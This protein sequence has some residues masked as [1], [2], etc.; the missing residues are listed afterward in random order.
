LEVTLNKERSTEEYKQVIQSVHEDVQ[1]MQQLTKSLLE[2]AKTGTQGSI[3]LSEVRIDEVLLKV[4]ADVQKNSSAYKVILQFG[5]FPDDDRA[6]LV[7]GNIDLLYSS[8]RNIADNGCKF[9]FDH[10][11]MI[12]LLFEN[13]NVIVQFTN[14]GD[15]I[16]EEEVEHIFQPFYRS[17]NASPIEGFG[18][19]LA[20]AKRLVAEAG[21]GLAPGAAFGPEGEGWLRWCFASR[22]P[23]RLVQGVERLQRFLGL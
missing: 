19:G 10:H 16:T 9:S 13:D 17:A 12:N 5:D 23:A 7:F 1:Q 20:L 18:F 14:Y 22:D 15:T 21:V 4:T 6:F 11:V 3:E 2:I 8:L